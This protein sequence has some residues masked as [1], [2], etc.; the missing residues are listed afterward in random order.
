MPAKLSDSCHSPSL[1]PRVVAE[2]AEDHRGLLTYASSQSGPNSVRHIGPN[3]VGGVV[4]ALAG[5]GAVEWGT[6]DHR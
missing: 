1:V 3:D 4:D 2:G 5:V 6:G